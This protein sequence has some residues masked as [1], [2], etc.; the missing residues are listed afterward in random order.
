MLEGSQIRA[1]LVF[2]DE[3]QVELTVGLGDQAADGDGIAGGVILDREH[4]SIEYTP[5][6][7]ETI[8][9]LI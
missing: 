6:N 3:C 9:A 5:S 4:G 1:A 7:R 8:S 2:G